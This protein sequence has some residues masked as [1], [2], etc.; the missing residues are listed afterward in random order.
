MG[1]ETVSL[2]G[3]IYLCYDP[4]SKRES[5]EWGYRGE[6]LS[7]KA[8]L[9]KS[10]QKIMTTNFWDCTLLII[11]K[12]V[13]LLSVG[14]TTLPCCIEIK[15]KR[16]GKFALGVLLLQDNAPVHKGALRDCGFTEVDHYIYLIIPIWPYVTIFYF[17]L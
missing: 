14:H 13:I 12:S 9:S 11:L 3:I 5:M 10:T 8:K 2:L 1:D 7:R 6:A 17:Q 4:E 15:A 16:R